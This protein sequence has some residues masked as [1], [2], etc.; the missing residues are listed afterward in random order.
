MIEKFSKIHAFLSNFY[1]S[2][3]I[4]EG[5]EYATVE[6]AYQAAKTLNLEEKEDIRL[7][8]TAAI[9]KRLGRQ[10]KVRSNWDTVKVGVM[11]ELLARKFA[12]GS[13]L[14]SL[15][16]DTKDEELKEGNWWGDT[17][18]GV[19]NGKGENW[20]GKLLMERRAI[21]REEE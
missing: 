11:R 18:W 4:W 13:V 3:I 2:P 21:L 15:L 17:F 6:H 16:L 10:A 20:L 8:P 5:H 7:A 9:A 1:P 12:V 19:C 14:S